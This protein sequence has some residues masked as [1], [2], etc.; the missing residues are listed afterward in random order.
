MRVFSKSIW[1][2]LLLCWLAIVV[3]GLY[4]LAR[5][6]SAAGSTAI[7]PAEWPGDTKLVRASG[8]DTLVLIA[9]PKCPCTR[10]TLG[11]LARTMADCGGKLKTIVL[12]VRPS[13]TPAN[14][15]K[16]DLWDSAATIPG[17]SVFVDVGGVE[18]Q[19]FGAETSGQTILYSESGKL[20]FQGGITAVRGHEG[21]NAGEDSI[22]ALVHENE[23]V[24]KQ[25]PVFGCPLCNSTTAN[26]G[27]ALCHP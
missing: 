14:W 17:V 21:D 1:S 18:A 20:L 15:E 27:K 22:V 2:A 16:T 13:E 10:A 24:A 3:A 11:D 19:R 12:F 9:H 8:C 7:V 6:Q 25:T 4:G 23:P 26:S 5:Y